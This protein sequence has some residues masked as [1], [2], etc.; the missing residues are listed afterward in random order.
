MKLEN[1]DRAKFLLDTAK[2]LRSIR[3]TYD[4]CRAKP[5]CDKHD[6]KF[7]HSDKRFSIFSVEIS[8]EGY[9]GYYGNS[10]C[11]TLTSI[12]SKEAQRLLLIVLN[13]RMD[14]I[15]TEMA[16]EAEKNAEAIKDEAQK[17]L[18][19]AQELITSM[20]VKS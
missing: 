2:R 4:E 16:T 5:T 3:P 7:N 18:N 13:R 15:L 6:L 14:Q 20:G 9:T 8:L 17:E 19:A 12:D 11:S 1:L 10:S